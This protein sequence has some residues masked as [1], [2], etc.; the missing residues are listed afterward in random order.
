MKY[1]TLTPYYN[2][3]INTT[4]DVCSYLNGTMNNI[5]ASAFY[6][7]FSKT[8]PKEYIHPC[9]Y[10]GY[11]VATNLTPSTNAMALQFL[12]GKYQVTA[13][14][15]DDIDDNIFTFKAYTDFQENRSRKNVKRLT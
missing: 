5:L 15:Y 6:D 2:T 11:Y 7:A 1:R 10:F 12:S 13:R 8:V 3:V 4:I 14:F 9:P